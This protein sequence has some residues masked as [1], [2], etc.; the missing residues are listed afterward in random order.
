MGELHPQMRKFVDV[1]AQG[2]AALGLTDIHSSGV[3]AARFLMRFNQAPKELWPPIHHVQQRAIP[4]PGGEIP[5]RI[6]RPS[7]AH[8][9]PALVWFHGGGWV[10]GD[11]DGA[12]LVCRTLANR[13]GCAVLSV[14]YRLAPEAQC[15]GA[16]DDCYAATAWAA[17]A[18]KELDID[19]RRIAVAGDSAGGNLAACVALRA[20]DEGLPLAFQLLVYP[21]TRADFDCPSYRDNGEGY[22]LTRSAMQWFWDCYVPEGAD[23]RNPAV[24]PIHARSLSGLAPRAD[25]HRRVRPAARR[26]GGLWRGAGQGRRAG[27][28]S[29]LRGRHPRILWHDHRGAGPGGGRGHAPC[30]R[31]AARGVCPALDRLTT[32]APAIRWPLSL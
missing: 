32:C 13:A 7:D 31:R 25:H 10:L 17:G 24:A 23:R 5:L 22:S 28:G 15:P 18:A 14:D 12:E 21:V 30:R 29:P 9:L 4:G 26:W 6:Y 2:M 1:A 16:L 27:D 8:G 20:R 19:P 3:E 11:L